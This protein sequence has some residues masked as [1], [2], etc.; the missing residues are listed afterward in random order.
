MAPIKP[1]NLQQV[2]HNILSGVTILGKVLF[3]ALAGRL[4]NLLII[5]AVAH[6]LPWPFFFLSGS[7]FR[8]PSLIVRQLRIIGAGTSL[9]ILVSGLFVGFV[10]GLQFYVL[11][12]RYGQVEVIGAGVALTLFRELGPVASGLLFVGCACTSMTA[13]IG[14]KKSSEQ[15]AAMEIMAVDPIAREL[16]PRLWA[17]IISLPLLTVYFD[18]VGVFGSYL[19]AVKQIGIDEGA[20][21]AEMQERVYFYKDFVLGVVKSVFLA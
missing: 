6:A 14:L 16:S 9:I 2:K 19:I 3:V 20:F 7:A 15:I 4:L 21:W 11:L 17:S 18:A 12:S 5:W 10:L 8:R 13:A 1:N